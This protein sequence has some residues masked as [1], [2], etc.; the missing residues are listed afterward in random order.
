LRGER[1]TREHLR[2][3]F[4]AALTNILVDE[5]RVLELFAIRGGYERRNVTPASLLALTTRALIVI[6][7]PPLDIGTPVGVWLHLFPHRAIRTL[8]AGE[9]TVHKRRDDVRVLLVNRNLGSAVAIPYVVHDEDAIQ[10]MIRTA[11]TL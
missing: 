5:E 2:G 1:V 6:R 8:E 3:D 10:T 4:G 9:G 7:E 11:R